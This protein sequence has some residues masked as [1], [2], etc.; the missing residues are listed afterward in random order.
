MAYCR[1]H[2]E[3]DRPAGFVRGNIYD[4][5]GYPSHMRRHRIR[6]RE[7]AA[8]FPDISVAAEL[9]ATN[10]EGRESGRIVREDE[11]ASRAS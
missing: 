5:H 6:F 1:R 2:M 8:K 9:L 7:P 11:V 10:L 4:R 3:Q